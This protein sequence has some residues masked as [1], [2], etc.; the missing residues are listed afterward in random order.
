MRSESGVAMMTTFWIL[1][2]VAVAIIAAAVFMYL[3]IPIIIIGCLIL[4]FNACGGS[5]GRRVVETTHSN[6]VEHTY[7][8]SGN[9]GQI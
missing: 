3:L 6:S 1:F 9:V 8:R 7:N 4:A 5:H 2:L